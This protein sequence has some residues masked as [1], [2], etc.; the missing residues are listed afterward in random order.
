MKPLGQSVHQLHDLL[1]WQVTGLFNNLIQRHRHGINLPTTE[2][3]LK[4]EAEILRVHSSRNPCTR[5]AV[6][7]SFLPSRSSCSL[8]PCFFTPLVFAFRFPPPVPGFSLS[9]FCFVFVAGLSDLVFHP[10]PVE[11]RALGLLLAGGDF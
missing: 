10:Q 2:P 8:R 6:S 1:S 5:V 4:S 11:Q 9:A 3:K 7:D